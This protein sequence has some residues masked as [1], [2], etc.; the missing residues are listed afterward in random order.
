MRERTIKSPG[1]A[2]DPAP[3]DPHHAIMAAGLDHLRIEGR[4]TEDPTDDRPVEREAIRDDH[5][6]RP[7]RHARRDVANERQGVPVAASSLTQQCGR[8]TTPRGGLTLRDI[9]VS[10]RCVVSWLSDVLA[11]ADARRTAAAAVMYMP[12]AA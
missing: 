2:D 5:G 9:F 8:A 1:G 3:V 12:V 6:T 4:R 11:F 10:L 7:E